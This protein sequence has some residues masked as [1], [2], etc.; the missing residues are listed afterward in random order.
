MVAT[1]AAGRTAPLGNVRGTGGGFATSKPL[2]DRF[3]ELRDDLAKAS[4]EAI[5]CEFSVASGLLGSPRSQDRQQL[6][7][8]QLAVALCAFLEQEVRGTF[9]EA[10]RQANG[11]QDITVSAGTGSAAAI[12]QCEE[13]GEE[14]RRSIKQE[15]AK[16]DRLLHDVPDVGSRL[17]RLHE[18]CCLDMQEL[19][20]LD[21][22]REG[23]SLSEELGESGGEDREPY[24]SRARGTLPRGGAAKS[25]AQDAGEAA[26]FAA[27]EAC[28]LVKQQSAEES[29]RRALQLEL[30]NLQ[31][32]R[33]EE[34][35]RIERLRRAEAQEAKL[36]ESH[37]YL[38]E[39][40]RR[41]GHA[42]VRFDD[43]SGIVVLGGP[44]SLDGVPEALRTV[45]V[46]YGTDGRLEGL[47]PHQTLG[48][49]REAAAAIED[50]DLSSFLTQC[51]SQLAH[52]RERFTSRGA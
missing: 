8:P 19:A 32:A 44:G 38:S 51:C 22:A 50:D 1:S 28:S 2:A 20:R 41:F 16:Q 36:T 25:G 30:L 11:G 40:E 10:C 3:S 52:F 33:R 45:R 42:K 14:M 13:R 27:Q 18:Q 31:A 21:A 34:R 15:L 17:R 7:D 47:E 48:L 29:R 43:S 46:R 26:I 35:T 23:A 24:G 49:H 37:E 5:P 4:P 9:A 12:S 6:P 39:V